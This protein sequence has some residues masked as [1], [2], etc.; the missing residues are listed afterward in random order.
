MDNIVM[1]TTNCQFCGKPAP[2]TTGVCSE[3]HEKNRDITTPDP[4]LT[5]ALGSLLSEPTL[6]KP[7]EVIRGPIFHKVIKECDCF[8][9]K[10]GIDSKGD[11]VWPDTCPC[12]AMDGA[13]GK[14][15]INY[16]GTASSCGSIR[17]GKVRGL[18]NDYDIDYDDAEITCEE[19]GAVFNIHNI[20]S[21]WKEGTFEGPIE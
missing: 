13:D 19:C 2:T 5:K 7:A 18:E 20:F 3:C 4:A 10:F 15:T 21:K 8:E 16:Y 11:M 9:F 17:G 6:P 1:G 14:L 12:C